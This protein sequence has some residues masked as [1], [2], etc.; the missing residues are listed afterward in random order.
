MIAPAD[1]PETLDVAIL[2]AHIAVAHQGI[3]ACASIRQTGP[4]RPTLRRVTH[5][6]LANLTLAEIHERGASAR[7]LRVPYFGAN[8][9]VADSSIKDFDTWAEKSA[10]WWA[11]WLTEDRGRD[12]AV[13]A[14]VRGPRF[15]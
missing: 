5:P 13:Q 6:S 2:G 15:R 1:V 14:H 8:P 7:R 4:R 9:F 12:A 10:A 11:G 3:V